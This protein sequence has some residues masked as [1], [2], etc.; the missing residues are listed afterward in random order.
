[1]KTRVEP[2]FKAK[3]VMR[4]PAESCKMT[5][6]AAYEPRSEPSKLSLMVW[7]WWGV[8]VERIEWEDENGE[9]MERQLSTAS[10]MVHSLWRNLA[11]WRILCIL[12][13]TLLKITSLHSFQILQ[14]R[15]LYFVIAFVDFLNPDRVV[16][17]VSEERLWGKQNFKFLKIP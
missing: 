10:L 8:E 13:F 6:A 17:T 15:K 2:R 16:K 3:V 14:R 9:P 5:L 4:S 7:L 1:M 12:R 11:S